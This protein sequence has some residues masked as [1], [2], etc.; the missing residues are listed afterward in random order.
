ML[1]ILDHEVFI[2]I[3]ISRKADQLCVSKIFLKLS[4]EVEIQMFTTKIPKYQEV[5][6]Y[7]FNRP[8]TSV[9]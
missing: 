9:K 1:Y 2:V 3:V 5:K 4:I 6:L 8:K 7:L